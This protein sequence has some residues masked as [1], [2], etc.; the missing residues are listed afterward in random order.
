MSLRALVTLF[1]D[2]VK[3]PSF[4]EQVSLLQLYVC[5]CFSTTLRL[6]VSSSS[7]ICTYPTYINA[8][9]PDTMLYMHVPPLDYFKG[10]E[11]FSLSKLLS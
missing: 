5:K 4:V 9:V 6:Y 7:A 1:R 2:E 11:Y 10:T 8:Y 3:R